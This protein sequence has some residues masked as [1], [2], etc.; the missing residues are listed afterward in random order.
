MG[1]EHNGWV[2]K[3]LMQVTALGVEWLFNVSLTE[4]RVSPWEAGNDTS[5]QALAAWLVPDATAHVNKQDWC[6]FLKSCEK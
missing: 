3:T 4:E 1:S 6:G 2:M 5:E